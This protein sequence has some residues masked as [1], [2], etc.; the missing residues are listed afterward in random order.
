[1]LL[2]VCLKLLLLLLS[3][4]CFC[5]FSQFSTFIY[6][7]FYEKMIHIYAIYTHTYT[8]SVS[9]TAQTHTHFHLKNCLPTKSGKK[10]I[11][12]SYLAHFSLCYCLS[13]VHA[14]NVVYIIYDEKRARTQRTANTQNTM[15]LNMYK[16][17]VF[18]SL[19]RLFFA[20][21]CVY[22][23]K[24]YSIRNEMKHE[25][26]KLNMNIVCKCVGWALEKRKIDK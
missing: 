4:C 16:D 22:L 9:S 23:V 5:S 18:F 17:F 2:L 19:L 24:V 12:I 13:I 11:K 10:W 7:I 3:R 8:V 1:M 6:F 26:A 15:Q 21:D 20:N 25:W 14:H